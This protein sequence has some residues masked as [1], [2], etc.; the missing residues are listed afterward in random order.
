HYCASILIGNMVK[1]RITD[2]R[3]IIGSIYEGGMV[4]WIYKRAELIWN[5]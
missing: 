1:R 2:K 4:L 3:E 5:H